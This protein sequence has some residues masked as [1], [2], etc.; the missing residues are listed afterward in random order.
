MGQVFSADS[1]TGRTFTSDPLMPPM[2]RMFGGTLLASATGPK[3]F[4]ARDADTTSVSMFQEQLSKNVFSHRV[5]QGEKG[6]DNFFNERIRIGA[7]LRKQR[8]EL[9]DQGWSDRSLA[10]SE[11]RLCHLKLHLPICIIQGIKKRVKSSRALRP[12]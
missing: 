12:P 11:K 10:T 5:S 9:R 6:F 1:M 2:L 4:P 7:C 3:V 8:F